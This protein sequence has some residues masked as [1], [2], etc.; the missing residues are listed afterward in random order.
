[1]T[2]RGAAS[3]LAFLV[4]IA[5]LSPS[6]SPGLVAGQESRLVFASPSYHWTNV[7]Q[8][9][10]Q[11]CCRALVYDPLNHSTFSVGPPT[12]QFENGSWFYRPGST[13]DL[14]WNNTRVII[15][16]AT[17]DADA[18]TILAVGFT[19]C[20]TH[21]AAPAPN[22]TLWSW[23][24]WSWSYLGMIPGGPYSGAPEIVYDSGDHYDLLSDWGWS[25]G[26]RNATTEQT[27][28]YHQGTWA[29][30]TAT[31]NSPLWARFSWVDD[32]A[33]SVV[34]AFGGCLGLRCGGGVE[35][36]TATF[37][38]G[39][40]TNLTSQESVAP[41]PREDAAISFS[42]ECDC[43]VLFGGDRGFPFTGPYTVF[44]DTWTFGAG[45]WTNVTG[46]GPSPPGQFFQY[47]GMADDPVNNAV[48][49]AGGTTAYSE[50]NGGT[51]AWGHYSA[52]A[53][54]ATAP[55]PFLLVLELVVPP[56]LIVLAILPILVRRRR[57]RKVPPPEPAS[58]STW[59]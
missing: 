20:R 10:Y 2:C 5:L 23:S 35:A 1:M 46:S 43:V 54:V 30:I 40:W 9:S 24:S 17:F 21:C 49:L 36:L 11:P 39:V 37:H 47:P 58:P 28:T 29:N 4:A 8:G 33:T 41:S 25:E 6:G 59:A 44:D 15:T 12:D 51:W 7:T 22:C 18:G 31:S 38:Q 16:S 56:T 48:L 19:V 3:I 45:G 26:I 52:S 53:P 14:P 32:S 34:V 50:R 27:W 42:S 13:L 57:R 55:F